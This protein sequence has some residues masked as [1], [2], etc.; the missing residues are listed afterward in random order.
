M[1]S[2]D[3]DRRDRGLGYPP[4][5]LSPKALVILFSGINYKFTILLMFDSSLILVILNYQYSQIK[6]L[7]GWGQ[8]SAAQLLRTSRFN[9]LIP[10][11]EFCPPWGTIF[12]SGHQ[13]DEYI[14]VTTR[15]PSVDGIFRF[16]IQKAFESYIG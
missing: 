5:R 12:M 7:L 15:C 6:T 10:E 8:N 2:S 13:F 3:R 9:P 14:L 4:P 16:Y 1:R 11:A